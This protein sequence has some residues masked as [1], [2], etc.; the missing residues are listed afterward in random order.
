MPLV[1]RSNKAIVTKQKVQPAHTVK[2]SIPSRLPEKS[3]SAFNYA[4]MKQDLAELGSGNEFYELQPGKNTV[5]FLMNPSGDL[6]YGCFQQVF[7]PSSIPG[8]KGRAFVSPKTEARDAYCP[9]SALREKL[10]LMAKAG[11][12]AAS[13]LA[14]QLK[15]TQSWLSNILAQN[16][17]GTWTNQILRYGR[18]IFKGVCSYVDASVDPE[19]IIDG[20]LSGSA[21]IADSKQ[22]R[23]VVITKTGRGMKTE[24]SVTVR[25]KVLPAT[26]EQLAARVDLAKYTTPSDVGDIEAALCE[27]LDADPDQ[28]QDLLDPECDFD[29]PYIESNRPSNK[30]RGAKTP[31]RQQSVNR[32]GKTASEDDVAEE[33]EEEED[34]ASSSQSPIPECFGNYR[35]PLAGLSCKKCDE[36][37][38]CKAIQVV[39]EDE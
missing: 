32:K 21:N 7:I 13:A 28:F 34:D 8:E 36:A 17:A 9:A 39:G 18:M 2:T 1:I 25:D 24:Y 4:K 20:L 16:E 30:V 19:D 5:R 31:A 3:S 23:I 27:L 35:N 12:E 14:D 37:D 15:P 11:N 29:I 33:D 6:F 26:R 38:N 22:G 10:L